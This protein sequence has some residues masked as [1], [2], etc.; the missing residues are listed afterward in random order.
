MLRIRKNDQTANKQ[1]QNAGKDPNKASLLSQDSNTDS[2]LQRLRQNFQNSHT[3]SFALSFMRPHVHGLFDAKGHRISFAVPQDLKLR[4]ALVSQKGNLL[5]QNLGRSEDHIKIQSATDL[6]NDHEVEPTPVLERLHYESA[7]PPGMKPLLIEEIALEKQRNKNVF[8]ANLDNLSS[9]R[10]RSKLTVKNPRSMRCKSYN[11]VGTFYQTNH[12]MNPNSQSEIIINKEIPRVKDLKIIK[13]I[14]IKSRFKAIL[15]KQPED[16]PK[17]FRQKS[18]RRIIPLPR[19]HTPSKS[20]ENNSFESSTSKRTK[21]KGDRQHERSE[22]SIDIIPGKPL[23]DTL[24]SF[25]DTGVYYDLHRMRNPD[26][27]APLH[28]WNEVASVAHREMLANTRVKKWRVQWMDK[29]GYGFKRGGGTME[30]PRELSPRSPGGTKI[31]KRFKRIPRAKRLKVLS[32]IERILKV[33][34]KLDMELV[35]QDDNEIF[36]TI[37]YYLPETKRLLNNIRKDRPNK[38]QEILAKNPN[39]V[40][41]FDDRGRTPLHHAVLA[42][43]VASF[44]LLMQ[45]RPDIDKRDFAGLKP[46]DMGVLGNNFYFVKQLILKGASPLCVA[47]NEE[48]YKKNLYRGIMFMLE[49]ALLVWCS[50]YLKNGAGKVRRDRYL[51]EVAAAIDDK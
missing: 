31:V 39:Y 25:F 18:N 48:R 12:T 6:Q 29:G 26:K 23:T 4:Y 34:A 13:D 20:I 51:R 3:S 11:D 40:Y 44:R 36:T 50:Q 38:V 1:L 45:Y 41:Q 47:F 17:S 46:L 22:S 37:P 19:K 43:S 49:E 33:K 21:S 9:R 30:S 15:H 27:Y 10:E 32:Q 35:Q 8:A 42:N 16:K 7:I 24:R 28:P 2:D 5:K 14:F